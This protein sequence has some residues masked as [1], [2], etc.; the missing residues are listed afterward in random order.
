M[1]MLA[2]GLFVAL[3]IFAFG[4]RVIETIGKDLTTID[5]HK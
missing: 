3:G 5:F 2:G 1:V 4:G